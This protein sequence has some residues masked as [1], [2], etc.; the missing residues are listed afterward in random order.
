MNKK[1]DTLLVVLIIL[2]LLIVGGIVY[3]FYFNQNKEPCV[4]GTLVYNKSSDTILTKDVQINSECKMVKKLGETFTKEYTKEV[5]DTA[6]LG[7]LFL[8]Y[9]IA[10]CKKIDTMSLTTNEIKTGDYD[11]KELSIK[12]F[13]EDSTP[14]KQEKCVSLK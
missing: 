13:V 1:A 6:G 5:G 8:D 2:S 4:T 11:G 3:Y 12:I 10:F 14:I 9:D 7:N